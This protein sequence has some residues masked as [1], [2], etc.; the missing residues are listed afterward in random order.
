MT[1]LRDVADA[2]WGPFLMTLILGA[3]L[4][5]TIGLRGM[6]ISGIPA[7]LRFLL[8]PAARAGAAGAGEISPF[9]ALMSALAATVGVGNIAGVAT[10]IHLGGPGA[11]FWMWMTALVGMATKYS[12]TFLAV[13]FRAE[14]KGNYLGGPMYYIK[15]GLG[16]RWAVLGTAYAVF[17]AIA[18]FGVGAS[19]QANTIADVLQTTF[20][21]PTWFAAAILVLGTFAVLVGGLQRIAAASEVL[22]PV[23][24]VVFLGVGVIVLALNA[25]KLPHALFLIL[26]SAFSGTAAAG[27]FAGST[28]ALAMRYGVARGIFS[29]EAGLGSAAIIH[30][31]AKSNDPVRLGAIGMLGTFIDTLVVNSMTALVIISTGAWTSGLT[32]ASLTSQ[33]YDHALPGAGAF[34]VAVSLVL[35]AFTTILGWSVYGE[36]CAA[37]LCGVGIVKPYR[38]A[39]CAAVGVGALVRL[40]MVWLFADIMNALMA[41]PNIV[42][43]LALSPTIFRLTNAGLARERTLAS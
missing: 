6:S 30:S 34:I 40:D 25:A 2:L 28:L 31:A 12:E 42:A 8:S 19:V 37:F 26:S 9:A 10:A 33:A 16:S 24:I 3:G 36:R 21:I 13:T 15:L 29:N 14:V 7:A 11:V 4:Y 27:G 5:L 32:A 1:I 38:Y 23:M 17:G 22:V 41:L 35:F 20:A 39:W 18:A 43:L